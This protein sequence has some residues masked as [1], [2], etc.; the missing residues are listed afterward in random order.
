MRRRVRA[1]LHAASLIGREVRAT[2][3]RAV[4]AL[5]RIAIALERQGGAR[6]T[7]DGYGRVIGVDYPECTCGS[8]D[9]CPRHRA[10]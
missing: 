10:K 6:H 7:F 2:A 3:D 8:L 4:M 1:R 5:E 9:D